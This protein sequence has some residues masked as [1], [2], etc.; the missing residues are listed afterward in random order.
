[1]FYAGTYS[2]HRDI[3]VPIDETMRSQSVIE[4]CVCI[5]PLNHPT[6]PRKFLARSTKPIT[7]CL[8]VDYRRSLGAF[9][10]DMEM[11][12]QFFAA[13]TTRKCFG[14]PIGSNE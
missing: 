14:A 3:A 8:A 7:H 1:M 6:T 11:I 2:F 12:D 13:G 9:F 4:L 5:P 10:S